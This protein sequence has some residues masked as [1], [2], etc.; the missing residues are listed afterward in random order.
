M[1]PW[2]PGAGG[3]RLLHSF[4]TQLLA[5]ST[6]C[7][8]NTSTTFFFF[9]A[10][11]EPFNR[12][13]KNTRCWLSFCQCQA[14]EMRAF[15]PRES[16]GMK[17]WQWDVFKNEDTWNN[18]KN[19]AGCFGYSLQRNKL[20]QNLAACHRASKLLSVGQI[21]LNTC[22]GKLSFLGRQPHLFV[23]MSSTVA[24]TLSWQGWVMVTEIAWLA[25]PNIVAIWPF[26]GKVCW[27]P[28]YNN[29]LFIAHSSV[30]W[31]CFSASGLSWAHSSTSFSCRVSWVMGS[32]AVAGIT[33]PLSL[34]VVCHPRGV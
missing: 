22:F 4:G 32:G 27:L 21:W 10:L 18:E 15:H 2:G 25:K 29:D 8:R 5:S 24:V 19:V 11:L 13:A 30:V 34:C 14:W 7:E 26:P 12:E 17:S 23:S 9:L 6:P 1:E 31:L 33:E 16:S 3:E 20:S 28:A